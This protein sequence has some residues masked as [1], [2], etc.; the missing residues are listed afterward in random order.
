[1]KDLFA[2]FRS[3]PGRRASRLRRA[4]WLQED[5]ADRLCGNHAVL[6]SKEMKNLFLPTK[7]N[8]LSKT[9][10]AAVAS[11]KGFSLGAGDIEDFCAELTTRELALW[12]PVSAL[13]ISALVNCTEAENVVLPLAECRKTLDFLG[14]MLPEGKTLTLCGATGDFAGACL[15]GGRLI[16]E[17]S[18]GDWCGAGMLSGQ[19]LVRG[20]VGKFTGEWM[21]GGRIHV[22]GSVGSVGIEL[23]GGEIYQKGHRLA[24][25]VQ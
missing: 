24:S 3:L 2:D 11:L 1:M 8:P 4:M 15:A 14:Y 19:I 12:N 25:Q 18:T 13:F 7:E 6:L 23:R 21:Q 22:D 17:G 16:I 9:Y 5:L 20:S 10:A